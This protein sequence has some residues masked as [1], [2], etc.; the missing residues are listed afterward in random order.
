MFALYYG[1]GTW[2]V[3]EPDGAL[4]SSWHDPHYAHLRAD[5]LNWLNTPS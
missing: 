1:E 5:L 2:V 3:C 4:E